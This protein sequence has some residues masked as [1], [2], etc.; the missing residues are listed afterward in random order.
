[1]DKLGCNWQET[2]ISTDIGM[3]FVFRLHTELIS[4]C[5][6]RFC[7]QSASTSMSLSGEI[8][9]VW[10]VPGLSPCSEARIRFEAGSCISAVLLGVFSAGLL[11]LVPSFL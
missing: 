1:M 9:T 3:S 11:L 2:G 10:A 7:A 5:V 4:C 8:L 6:G